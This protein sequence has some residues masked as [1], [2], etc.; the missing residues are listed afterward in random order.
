VAVSKKETH[1]KLQRWTDLIAALLAR[2]LGATFVEL[3]RDVPAYAEGKDAARRDSVKRAFE[4]DK[5]ELRDFGV[6]IET[7]G[8]SDGEDARYRLRPGD[9]YLPYLSLGDTEPR[10]GP[11]GYRSLPTV[12]LTPDDLALVAEAAARLA[13]LGDATLSADVESA[14]NKLAFDLPV[15]RGTNADVQLL[16]AES[17]TDPKVFERLGDALRRRKIVTFQYLKP[18]ADGKTERRVEPLGLFFVNAFW[19]LAGRDRSRD[20]I[21]NFRLSRMSDI[22]VNAKKPQTP[23]FDAPAGFVLR[24]HAKAKDSWELGDAESSVAVVRFK[25]KLD[26]AGAAAAKLGEAVPGK[27]L[28]RRFTVKRV[29]AFSR[30]LLALGGQARPVSP[31]AV[32]QHFERIARDTLKVYAR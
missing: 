26:G 16:D 2:R 10:I 21:R 15:F 30:W 31:P 17:G 9:F 27:A 6:P 7:L 13:Q 8:T 28:D 20:A 14:V 3:A 25:R 19:Y 11:E 32:V 4:R 23:D 12:T 1:S 5:D 18:D 22:D 24:D 29:D